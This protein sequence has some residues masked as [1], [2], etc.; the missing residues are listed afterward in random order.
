MFAH[1][2]QFIFDEISRECMNTSTP[3]SPLA[4]YSKVEGE[5]VANMM[6]KEKEEEKKNI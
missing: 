4:I 3:F 6:K 5:K 1:N 2:M